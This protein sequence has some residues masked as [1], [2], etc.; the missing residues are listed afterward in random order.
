MTRGYLDYRND[1]IRDV[2]RD[3]R[4]LQT[5]HQH[6]ALPSNYGYRLDERVVEYPWVI[7]R[8]GNQPTFLLDA[9]STFNFDF[10]LGLDILTQKTIVIHT[11]APER[12]PA[13]RSNVS[14]IYGDLR[15][16]IC[17]INFSR[18]SCVF[19]R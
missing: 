14:Y 18:K 7:S 1:F 3:A 2:L 8:L 9:G 4:L 13:S 17:A 19:L 6:A 16:T 10:I 15:Q 11:L 5:F 12:N